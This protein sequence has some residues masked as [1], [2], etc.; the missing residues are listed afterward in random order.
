[1]KKFWIYIVLASIS[2]L[3][4]SCNMFDIHPYAGKIEG[5]QDINR[6]NIIK[7][8]RDYADK[9][10]IKYAFI[11]DSQRWHDDLDDFVKIVNKRSDIDFIIHG[12]D[13]SDFGLTKEFLWQRDIL[14]KLKQPY[15]A[16]LGNHDCLANGEEIFEQVFGSPNYSF[17]AGKTKFL[18]LNT[19]AL[20]SDYSTPVPDF[21]FI[22]HERQTDK[23]RFEQTVVVMHARPTSDQFNNNVAAVF[24]YSIR[25]Y[26]NLLYCSNGHDHTYQQED[27]FNDGIIYYG[28]PNIGKRQYLIFTITK[29]HYTHELVSY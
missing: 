17:I 29:D 15:V 28:T 9:D 2:L 5:R 3:I 8:E 26:P 1:M 20:E 27:I 24:Q 21:S 7:I 11:S 18:C 22:E 12:G 16:L 13:I 4:H 10:T 23:G 14:E 25:Q 19:N 6:D